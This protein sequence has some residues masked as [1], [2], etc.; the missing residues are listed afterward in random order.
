MA[1]GGKKEEKEEGAGA[2]PRGQFP[3]VKH[4]EQRELEAPLMTHGVAFVFKRKR[5]R[6]GRVP[7]PG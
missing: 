4:G 3:R 6:H 7:S 2:K 1:G 5:K